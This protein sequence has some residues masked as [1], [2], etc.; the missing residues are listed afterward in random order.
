M[1]ELTH[2]SGIPLSDREYKEI[3]DMFK[4]MEDGTFDDKIRSNNEE[5]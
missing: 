2:K 3:Q 1:S 4:R 5:K